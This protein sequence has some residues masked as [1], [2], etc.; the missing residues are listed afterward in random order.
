MDIKNPDIGT[1]IKK[2]R[3]LRNLKQNELA[4]K[5][6]IP[7]NNI[8][9]YEN[10]KVTPPIENLMKIAVALGITLGELTGEKGAVKDEIELKNLR[11][12]SAYL[13]DKIEQC[14]KEYAIIDAAITDTA[15][16]N[17]PEKIKE[18]F[19]RF[20]ELSNEM[21][22]IER[23]KQQVDENI[24]VLSQDLGLRDRSLEP[25]SAE[26]KLGISYINYL[27]T[28]NNNINYLVKPEY[29][30][31]NKI[32]DQ[33]MDGKLEYYKEL[34]TI[35]ELRFMRQASTFLAIIRRYVDEEGF[36]FGYSRD[37]FIDEIVKFYSIYEIGLEPDYIKENI[38]EILEK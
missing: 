7:T 3:K 37:S 33:I 35:D 20:K 19:E 24:S 18:L 34:F 2:Y 28:L 36:L 13:F 12:Y 16:I 4:K 31:E 30:N 5:A 27:Q 8:S 29:R 22:A 23:K 15:E 11:I 6:G 21:N 26:E 38:L 9:R 14:N 17:D 1:N 10:S 32:I 25:I